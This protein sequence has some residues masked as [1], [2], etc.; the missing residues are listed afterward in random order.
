MGRISGYPY[1]ERLHIEG[2]HKNVKENTHLLPGDT[3][4]VLCHSLPAS[5]VPGN[6][7]KY[8]LKLF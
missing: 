4:R 8:G 6:R 1:E 5:R 3:R 2:R 7:E